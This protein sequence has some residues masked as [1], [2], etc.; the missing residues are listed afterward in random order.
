MTF[1]FLASGFRV[2]VD[3]NPASD[4]GRFL[5]DGPG[6]PTL[7]FGRVEEDLKRVIKVF[8]IVTSPVNLTTVR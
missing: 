1:H 6:I 8:D 4:F 2:Q 3:L 7:A 5:S